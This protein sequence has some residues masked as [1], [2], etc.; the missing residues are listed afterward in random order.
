VKLLVRSI[1]LQ[2]TIMEAFKKYFLVE[3]TRLVYTFSLL[4]VFSSLLHFALREL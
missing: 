3:L 2:P 1:E 4:G